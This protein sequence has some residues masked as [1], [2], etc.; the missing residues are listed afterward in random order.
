[1]KLAAAHAIAA[2]VAE[3][4]ADC[5]VPSV[6]DERVAPHVAEAVSRLAHRYGQAS[7]ARMP[8]S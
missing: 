4:T 7:S 8:L 3:P 6:F 5:V 1:M 2:L